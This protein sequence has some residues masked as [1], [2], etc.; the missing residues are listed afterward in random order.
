MIPMSIQA[1]TRRL[2]RQRP[3]SNVLRVQPDEEIRNYAHYSDEG[4][5]KM[6]TECTILIWVRTSEMCFSIK[7]YPVVCDDVA[8]DITS[9][10]EVAEV[11]DLL[12]S[13]EEVHEEIFCA[14][15]NRSNVS[16]LLFVEACYKHVKIQQLGSR[17]LYTRNVACEPRP[18]RTDR[19]NANSAPSKRSA[20]LDDKQ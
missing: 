11:D 10:E 1:F 20:T 8:H 19:S 18:K 16:C 14:S 3:A 13:S 4:K 6:L 2:R 15:D 5:W 12:D 7:P 17:L 9:D